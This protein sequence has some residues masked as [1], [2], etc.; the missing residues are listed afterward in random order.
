MTYHFCTYFDRNYLVRGLA[1]YSSLKRQCPEYVLWVLCLDDETYTALT[2]CN[3][4]ECH[5]IPLVDIERQDGAL[6]KVKKT[7]SR[8]EYFFTMSPCLPLYIIDHCPEVD[9]ITYLDADLFFF[10]DPKPLYDELGSGSISIIAHRFSSKLSHFQSMGI[11]NVGWLS[12]RRDDNG[13]KCL[14]WWRERCI[15]DCSDLQKKAGCFADQK[16]LDDWPQRFAGVVVL[17]HK[18]ANLASWN[19][20]NYRLTSVAETQYVDQQILLFYH[21]HGLTEVMPRVYDPRLTEIG[22]GSYGTLRKQIYAPYI[23]A[24]MHVRK[25]LLAAG[26]NV[27][28]LQNVRFQSNG[29]GSRRTLIKQIEWWLTIAVRIMTGRYFVQIRKSKVCEDCESSS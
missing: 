25:A 7:R 28:L 10:A 6:H 9:V 12:F 23:N 2:Q 15:E 11:Y 26:I 13:M 1:L 18:G 29:G 5:L 20:G 4:P 14:R 3:L 27:P 17:Q 24:L 21:F 8:P 22:P 16:Y 19:V